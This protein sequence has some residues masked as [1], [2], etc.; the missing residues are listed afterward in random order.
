[1]TFT[2]SAD[3]TARE[4]RAAASAMMC[5]ADPTDEDWIRAINTIFAAAD[6][7]DVLEDDRDDSS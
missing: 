4:L 6:R 1:M 7:I 5:L 3:L 2:D